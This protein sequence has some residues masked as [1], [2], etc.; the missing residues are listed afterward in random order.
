[1]SDLI[2][3]PATEA[4]IP[5]IK[6][7]DERSFHARMSDT[8]IADTL[9]LLPPERFLVAVD[10]QDGLVGVTAAYDMAVTLPGGA[11]LPS[12]GVAWVSVPA[13]HRRRGILRALMAGQLGGF[14]AQGLPLAMLTASHASIYGR[15]GY[16]EATRNR[17][18][19]IDPRA[20]L[21]ADAPDPGGVRFA[22]TSEVTEHA[23]RIHR[24]WAAR[25]PGAV[26]RSEAWWKR[27][28]LDREYR[29]GGASSMFHLVHPDGWAAYRAKWGTEGSTL[30]VE[31][32]AVTPEAH[33]ALWRVL[34][35]QELVEKISTRLT[36]DDP[37]QLMLTD[38][39]LI[40][41]TSVADGLWLRVLDVP[42]VLGARRYG[43]EIDVVLEVRDDFLGRGGRF[44][45]QG[46]PDGASCTP[47]AGA[48]Q[49]HVGMADLGSLVTGNVRARSLAAAARLQA[50]DAAL[51]RFDVAFV[52]EREPWHG[53]D[54]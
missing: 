54:F 6:R 24:R 19:E 37:L 30:S 40:R 52:P 14:V 46:G 9:T 36:F 4:D 50:E 42:A 32:F 48:A 35:A 18:V 29:R 22:E 15:F 20:E 27:F 3:R 12:P 17:C 8:E 45:L 21:R 11:A 49:V 51:A 41:T 53:T 39:R 47:T 5:A 28:F 25:T 38:P 23:P 13:T 16:G 34:L 2:I 10:P 44:R 33:A 7:A 31:L 43:C 1:M 26:S